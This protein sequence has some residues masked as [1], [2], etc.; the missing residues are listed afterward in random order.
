MPTVAAG[1]EI[2]IR[3]LLTA[4]E[5]ESNAFAKYLAFAA[6]ADEDGLHGVASLFR[7]AGR[8]EQ[9]HAANHARVIKQLGGDVRCE[10]HK[11]EV[12]ST[13]ENLKTALG[14]ELHEAEVMY[15]E[16]LAEA[17][18]RKHGCHP[19]LHRRHG[20]GKDA[21]PPLW[22]SDRVAAGRKG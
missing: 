7:A 19:H 17:S 18:A 14:G 8:A 1:N 13:L 6:K 4:F 11:V 12:R 21:C 16:Y 3:N 9:I 10:I 2:T 15:P 5:G 22:R 20:S